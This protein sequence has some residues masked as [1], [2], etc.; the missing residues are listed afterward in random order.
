M[1]QTIALL[2]PGAI[3]RIGPAGFPFLGNVGGNLFLKLLGGVQNPVDEIDRGCIWKGLTP[4][5][6][7]GVPESLRRKNGKPIRLH[8]K[9][10][11][12]TTQK[13]PFQTE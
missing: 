12:G 2:L 1:C 8:H 5:R 9:G 6:T 13:L 7:E 10:V 4:P 11:G 3:Q